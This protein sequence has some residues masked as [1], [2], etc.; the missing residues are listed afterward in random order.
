MNIIGVDV[1]GTKIRAGRVSGGRIEKLLTIKTNSGAPQHE[2]MSQITSLIDSIIDGNTRGIGVAVPAII[3]VESGTAFETTNIASWTEVPI[4][5]ILEQKYNLPV[6]VNNDANCLAL[7]EKHFGTGKNCKNFV[8][9]TISTG[10]GAGIIANGEL[11]SGH[12][13]GAGEF[14]RV[15]FK[16][17]TFEHYCSGKYF[18]NEHKISGEELFKKAKRNDSAALNIF[19]AYGTNLG[20]ALAMIVHSTD[21]EL[22]ILCG[23]VSK[24]Y[25]YFEKS[26]WESLRQSI[27]RRSFS[28]L[29]IQLSTIK[30][31]GILGAASQFQPEA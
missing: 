1:G 16:E 17:H 19:D 3:D 8:A 7:C 27:R 30:N 15:V 25:K 12:N 26:M 20:K 6:R 9:L 18:L 11:Q 4:K 10:L 5:K 21:P 13:C 23:S 24:S 2:V 31:A 22:I 29:K 14:G 28:R